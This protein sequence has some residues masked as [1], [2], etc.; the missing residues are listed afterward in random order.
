[1]PNQFMSPEGDLENY[2][3]TEH[4]LID[5][6]IGD[7][8]WAWGYNYGN[9]VS[10]EGYSVIS[11][12]VTP[13]YSNPNN[14]KQISAGGSYA[15][16]I[17]TD[18]TLWTWGYNVDG[19]LGNNRTTIQY[20]PV[21]TFAGGTNW[22]QVS[23]GSR[24]MAA[25]KTDGTLWTWGWNDYQALGIF[26]IGS[27]RSTPVTTFA[28]GTNWKQVS[29]GT[30]HT[31]AIKT[32]GTLW[33]WG[34][35]SLGNL[36]IN[37]ANLNN[38]IST[39]TP[40]TTFAGGTNWKQ[41]ACGDAYTTAIKTDGTLWGWGRNNAG[42]LGINNQAS[43][44]STPVTTFAGGT[45]WKQV[46][47]GYFTAAIK[48]DGT[49][50]GWGRNDVGS[51]GDNTFITRSIPVTTFAGGTN[52][53]QVSC[54]VF[55]AAAIKTDGTLWNWGY[56]NYGQ[57]GLADVSPFTN[58]LTPVTT[59]SGGTNWKQVSCSLY[60]TFALTSGEQIDIFDPIIKR[61]PT[62]PP[63]PPPPFCP[64]PNCLILLSDGS[65]K[66][67]GFLQVGDLVKTYH[68]DTFEYGDYEVT[69]VSIIENSKKLKLIFEISEIIC[70]DSH[71][72]YVGNSWK[73]SKDMVIGDVVSGQKLLKIE[74]FEDGDVVKITVAD[75]HT[76]IC[77][78][79]LSHN[80]LDD[81]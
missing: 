66:K 79:L 30:Y 74:E 71:K 78:G 2:F 10:A 12:P 27:S 75:A 35:N 20:T 39:S 63:P 38:V 5:Q 60:S 54:G 3:V 57:M 28:G 61:F 53:K 14:W 4:W 6:Y 65:Q 19:A 25:I 44:R 52:W 68:E 16:A 42:Q 45:N 23:C 56:N 58:R 76:Y 81:N 62:P 77:E 59:I 29:C 13:Y 73:E 21:T 32:D 24:H 70:S 49:L 9:H 33:I 67:A 7:R 64:D 15:S 8:R 36:G 26:A 51:V 46:A 50:W 47:C 18:G 80:K 37:S 31:A 22:K 48:T 11:A 55:H 72:L 69:H 41:V 40:V 1:M 17:K 34:Y 43:I